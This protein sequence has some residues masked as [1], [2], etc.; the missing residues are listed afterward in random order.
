MV[1]AT[2]AIYVIGKLKENGH[3][4]R[5]ELSQKN[6]VFRWLIYLV[7]M[8]TVIITGFYGGAF[9]DAGMIYGQ[10]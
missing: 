6:L 3:D 4:I 1:V 10:F 5:L 7:L 9:G 8:F 2:I